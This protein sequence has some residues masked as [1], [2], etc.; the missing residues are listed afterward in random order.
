MALLEIG[1]SE[2][3]IAGQFVDGISFEATGS[4]RLMLP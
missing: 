2:V 4:I 1:K 3:L